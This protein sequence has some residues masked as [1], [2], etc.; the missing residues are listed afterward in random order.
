MQRLIMLT[1]LI[2]ELIS[3]DDKIVQQ[4]NNDP[5]GAFEDV[6]GQS[7]TQTKQPNDDFLDLI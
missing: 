2:S 1:S 3:F 6:K 7:K 5:F 4:S